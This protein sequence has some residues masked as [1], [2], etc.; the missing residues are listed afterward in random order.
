LRRLFRVGRFFERGEKGRQIGKIL[1]VEAQRPEVRGCDG[2]ERIIPQRAPSPEPHHARVV[3]VEHATE[4]KSA[5]VH[6]G[7]RPRHISQ[8]RRKKSAA[9][10]GIGADIVPAEIF[11]ALPEEAQ[12]ENVQT[13]V[14]EGRT[15]MAIH[16]PRIASKQVKSEDL[17][18]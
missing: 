6:E 4:R 16:A 9:V 2:N 17:G 10:R 15:M 1:P 14:A 8:R 13:V 5:R 18:I 7:L 3:H 11:V 12:T